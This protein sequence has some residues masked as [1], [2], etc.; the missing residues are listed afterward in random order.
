MHLKDIDQREG[1]ALRAFPLEKQAGELDP[2]RAVV[3]MPVGS[4]PCGVVKVGIS[5]M[6]TVVLPRIVG[7]RVPHKLVL[8]PADVTVT[9]LI[10]ERFGDPIQVMVIGDEPVAIMPVLPWPKEADRG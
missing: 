10:G 6:V 4:V 8:A 1:V 7:Q 2:C 3:H 5:L 9:P